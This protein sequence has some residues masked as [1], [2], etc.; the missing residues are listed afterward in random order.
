MRGRPGGDGRVG[1]RSPDSPDPQNASPP[2]GTCGLRARAVRRGAVALL[3]RNDRRAESGAG[4]AER[5]SRCL[6]MTAL[7]GDFVLLCAE[8]FGAVRRLSRDEGSF[9]ASALDAD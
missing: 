3:R 1:H 6:S 9:A 2:L 7:W 4:L 8:V 5:A